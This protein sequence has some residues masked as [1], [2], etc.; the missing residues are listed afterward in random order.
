M[1]I[2]AG[3][4]T[5]TII[6]GELSLE[7]NVHIVCKVWIFALKWS[8]QSA[9]SVAGGGGGGRGAIAHPHNAF[10]EFCRYIWKS[11]GTCKSTSM[12]FVPTKFLKYQQNIERNSSF[13][14][15][16]YYFFGS[17]APSLATSISSMLVSFV[18]IL[19][20]ILQC[21]TISILMKRNCIDC[22]YVCRCNWRPENIH[23]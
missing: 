20:C 15:W 19:S 9:T 22:H 3:L 4:H 10:S 23:V 17:L 21:H 7:W 8:W 16:K 13:L 18:G 6:S 2:W 11:V 12:S 5:A 14:M 1:N